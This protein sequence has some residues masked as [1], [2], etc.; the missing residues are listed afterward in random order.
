MK[1]SATPRSQSIAR[2]HSAMRISPVAAACA[3]LLLASGSVYA[4]NAPAATG[5][6]LGAVTVTGFRHAIE[7]SI[8]TKRNAD[9]IVEAVSAEDIGKLPDVSIAESLARL[10]GVA[11]IRGQDGRVQTISIRGLP[12]Q[13]A[14]TLLNGREMVSSGDNRSVEYDQFPSELF[15]S[16]VV[17]KTPTASL[18]GQGL[19]GTVD[20]RTVNPLSFAGRQ[21]AFNV[22]GESNSNGEAIAGVAGKYGQRF[23]A[24]YIDQSADKTLGWALGFAHLDTPTQ[25]RQSQMWDWSAPANDWGSNTVAGLPKATNGGSA[26]M[27]MGME[28]TAS[29]KSNKRDGLMGVLE[30]KP[31]KD[32]HSQ[33]DLYYSK[34]NA[35]DQ[36]F[37][38]EIS[39]WGLWN[40]P[41]TMPY[42]TNA[43]TT[44]FDRNTFVTSGVFNNSQTVLQSFNSSRTDEIASLGWNTSYNLNKNWKLTGDLSYSKDTRDEK[45]LETF[46]APYANGQWVMGSYNFVADPV[47]TKLIQLSPGAGTSFAS[48]SLRLGDP[49]NWVGDDVG[50]SG[51]INLPHVTDSM[52]TLR[53]TAKRSLDGIFSE[54]D[55]GFNYTQRDKAVEMN[56]YRLNIANPTTIQ[57]DGG[58]YTSTIPNGAVLGLV[59]LDFAGLTGMP[60]LDVQNLVDN[61]TLVPQ[62]VFWG[63]AG[64]DSTVHE[65]V[66]T[67]YAMA[68]I[69]THIGIVPVSGNV[70]V[71]FVRTDQSSEGWVYL[72]DT[73]NP[74]LS[75]LYAVKGGTS[76]NDV[77]PSLNL[78]FDLPDQTVMRVGAGRQVAR[79]NINDIRAGMSGPAVNTKPGADYATW[80]GGDGGNPSLEPWRATAYDFSLEKYF[81]KRS[82]I[83]VAEYYKNLT[84]WVY[85][86][87]VLRDFTGFPNTSGVTPVSPYGFFTAPANGQGGMVRGFE[88]T[89][90]LDGSLFSKSLDGIG[91]IANTTIATSSLFA[92]NG[93]EVV[94]E[95]MSGRSTNLTLYY[96]QNGFSARISERYRSPFTTTYRTVVFENKT[97]KISSDDVVDL[98]LGYSFD[99]GYF[100]GLSLMFQVNNLTDSAT[101]QMQTING[102]DGQNPTPNKS[103]LVTKYVNHFGR[104]MLFG[105]NYKF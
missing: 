8:E 47:G 29:S 72:G 15:S 35:A 58:R 30:F 9:S 98:Q 57:A 1:S 70:G 91:V 83:A 100:K 33:L 79:P 21:L 71:Q 92:K 97:T 86:E 62:Q 18:V 74:D 7:T 84:S 65:K 99:Q 50:F 89:I 93:D 42:L 24:S 82:Y 78:R 59:N 32:L 53:L 104:Q 44:D 22:R 41:S 103:Q 10:P 64:D 95:G 54:A 36:G 49:M 11:G 4:Q 90:S 13:F 101:Q 52:K 23:S 48:S 77:L 67:A 27:P 5:A 3:S 31:N 61:K 17:Y 68:K 56:R 87:K 69:D 88:G 46:A 75:K 28:V 19:A 66:S 96:E 39:N 105:M 38:F 51:N 73:K 26:L 60:R 43:K 16:A 81:G 55:F 76:Y 2:R 6:N 25:V 102:L 14:T 94:P 34:F 37:K 85:N 12:P 20:L 45:Y 40:G 80:S 63:K